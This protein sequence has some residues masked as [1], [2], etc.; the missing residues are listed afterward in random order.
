VSLI[1]TLELLLGLP[2]MNALDA[3]AV[4]LDLFGDTPDLTPYVAVLPQVAA[5]N[6]MNPGPV[7]AQTAHWIRRTE[8]QN[9]VHADLADPGVLNQ[10][11]WF[12]VRGAASPAPE[13]ARLPAFDA[14]AYGIAEEAEEAGEGEPPG[15]I[16]RLRT[17]LARGGVHS[18][19]ATTVGEE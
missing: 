6:R 14:L 18:L 8:E 3:T 12:S 4:P 15:V 10:I 7:D 19:D 11:L 13:L 5:D 16:E 1:R 2:P 9:L 17:L